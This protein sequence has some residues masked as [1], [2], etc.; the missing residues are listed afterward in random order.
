[1]QGFNRTSKPSFTCLLIYLSTHKSRSIILNAFA[2]NEPNLCHF[3]TVNADCE[4]KQTQ[5][6]PNSKPFSPPKTDPISKTSPIF[7]L[8]SLGEGGQT[9]LW[10]ALR[11]NFTPK[12]HR[13]HSCRF[14]PAIGTG[15]AALLPRQ[16]GYTAHQSFLLFQRKLCHMSHQNLLTHQLDK[17]LKKITRIMW[18]RRSLGVILNRKGRK[19]RRTNPL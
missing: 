7:T 5:Y 17:I 14:G 12:N 19:L 9:S 16:A 4:E 10:D 13:K 1:M 3:C 8:H 2:Q 18:S 11:S 15:C 6:K